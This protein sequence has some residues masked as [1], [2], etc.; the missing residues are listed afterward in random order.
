MSKK[1]IISVI[2][3]IV[4]IIESVFIVIL[5]TRNTNVDSTVLQIQDEFVQDMVKAQEVQMYHIGHIVA[6]SDENFI[7]MD[8]IKIGSSYSYIPFSHPKILVR[9]YNNLNN[10]HTL[11]KNTENTLSQNVDTTLI[12]ETLKGNGILIGENMRILIGILNSTKYS[13]AEKRHT[14]SLIKIFCLQ[15][16][17]N[18]F[19]NN[20]TPLSYAKIINYPEKDTVRLG[21]TYRSQILFSPMDVAGNII[22]LDNGDT[23]K[24][25][26]FEEKATKKGWNHHVGKMEILNYS[27]CSFFDVDIDYFVK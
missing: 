27:G 18:M 24:Y 21:D 14:L 17:I 3:F 9:Y 15:E 20:A 25:G 8:T 5:C 10:I 26:F 11:L 6:Q 2:L 22:V 1:N 12:T 16:S 19:G 13:L 23:I 4:I 7:K